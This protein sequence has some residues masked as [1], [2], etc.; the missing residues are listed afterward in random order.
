MHV[1]G[2][3]FSSC[4][5]VVLFNMFHANSSVSCQMTHSAASDVAYIVYF[6]PYYGVINELLNPD[7]VHRLF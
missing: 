3:V 6:V 1:R 7:M 4:G 5:S 2:Y